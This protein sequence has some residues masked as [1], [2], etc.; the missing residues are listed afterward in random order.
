MALDQHHHRGKFTPFIQKTPALGL[1]IVLV[2]I[3][4]VNCWVD[5]L[6]VCI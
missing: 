4:V 6:L 2:V 1:I 3:R 5:G